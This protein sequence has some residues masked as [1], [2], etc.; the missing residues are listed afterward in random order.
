MI[1]LTGTIATTSLGNKNLVSIESL[2]G[3]SLDKSEV[4]IAVIP[5]ATV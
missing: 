5:K 4:L 2:M 1:G 3:A